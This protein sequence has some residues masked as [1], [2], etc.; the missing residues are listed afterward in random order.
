MHHLSH[1][2]LRSFFLNRLRT[3][4]ILT[5][6]LIL[7]ISSFFV[8]NAVTHAASYCQVTYTVTNQ[9]SGAFWSKYHRPEHQ[10]LVMVELEARLHI[11]SKRSGRYSGMECDICPVGPERDSDEREL[12]CHGCRQ[13]ICQ[14]WLQRYLDL[15]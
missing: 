5:S 10:W 11:P 14:P 3:L 9:W 7:V 1:G 6:M 15:K 4:V 12:Q 8:S 2:K 13:C